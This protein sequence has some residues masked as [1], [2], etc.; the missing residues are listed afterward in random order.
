MRSS[1]DSDVVLVDSWK[2]K[3]KKVVATKKETTPAC[4]PKKSHS[5]D[6]RVGLDGLGSHLSEGLDDQHFQT[7]VKSCEL[8][9]KFSDHVAEVG[10]SSSVPR[11]ATILLQSN[12]NLDSWMLQE[13]EHL[14]QFARELPDLD[15][16]FYH[17]ILELFALSRIHLQ[18]GKDQVDM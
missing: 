13:E 18:R 1:A 8:S 12:G 5:D 6:E 2:E 17:Q 10:P 15:R 3:R 7:L 11:L 9:A 14:R 16:D 4:S